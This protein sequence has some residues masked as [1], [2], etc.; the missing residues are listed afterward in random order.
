MDEVNWPFSLA[1]PALSM[2]KEAMSKIH[3]E[4]DLEYNPGSG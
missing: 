4:C 2:N 1:Q 3:Y